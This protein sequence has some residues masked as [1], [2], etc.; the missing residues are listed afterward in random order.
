HSQPSNGHGVCPIF[1]LLGWQSQFGEVWLQETRFSWRGPPSHQGVLL[2]SARSCTTWSVVRQIRPEALGVSRQWKSQGRRCPRGFRSLRTFGR[3]KY[4]SGCGAHG[5]FEPAAYPL[6]A[7]GGGLPAGV[8][9]YVPLTYTER[10]E[11]T[12][13]G[14]AS[15]RTL[16]VGGPLWSGTVNVDRLFLDVLQRQVFRRGFTS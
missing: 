11:E 3:R 7:L 1:H 13:E 14:P 2:N 16:G 9:R 12:G 8:R 4:R 6:T 5:L 15:S 10:V